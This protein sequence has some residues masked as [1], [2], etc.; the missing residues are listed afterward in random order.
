MQVRLKAVPRVRIELR[1][2]SPD[3]QSPVRFLTFVWEELRMPAPRFD[4]WP[5]KVVWSVRVYQQAGRKRDFIRNENRGPPRPAS[6]G[7][8]F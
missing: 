2:E 3:K 1:R 5:L 6:Y 8:P 7:N 4:G